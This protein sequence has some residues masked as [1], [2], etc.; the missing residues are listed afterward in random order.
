MNRTAPQTPRSAREAGFTLIE[1]LVS[2]TIL[3]AILGLLAGGLGTISKNWLSSAERIET[4]DMVARA[5]D[6]LRR[7]AAGMQRIVTMSGKTPRYIFT[8]TE[9]RLSFVTLEPPYP[10]AAGPYFVEYAV[11]RNGPDAELVRSRARYQHG[12]ETFPGA[13]PANRV[14]LVQGRYRYH[15]AYADRSTK[16]GT[17]LNTWTESTRLPE[18]IRLQIFDVARDAPVAPPFVVA[19]RADAELGCLADESRVCSP[20][21]GGVLKA[22]AESDD[23]DLK[24]KYRK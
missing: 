11:A 20:K 24:S 21:T 9:A 17:W 6:I 3:A 23:G 10:S 18:L 8:G 22:V 14:P 4:L 15:F 2:L 12:L 16:A 1:L 5:G 19:L 13:T 7:D